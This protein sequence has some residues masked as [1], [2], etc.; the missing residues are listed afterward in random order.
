MKRVLIVDDEAVIREGMKYLI[1]WESLGY[2][3][4]GTAENGLVGLE[5]IRKLIPDLVMLDIKMPGKTGLQMLQEAREEGYNFHSIILSGYSDFEYA[6]KAIK[7]RT[8]SYLLKPVD[9]DELKE[10]LIDLS[11]KDEKVRNEKWTTILYDKLFGKDSTG[12][13]EYKQAKLIC[14]SSLLQLSSQF[15]KIFK[16]DIFYFT[17]HRFYYLLLTNN[18]ISDIEIERILQQKF[19]E[20][21]LIVT[22]WEEPS[23]GLKRLT[24]SV[25][26][27]SQFV[28]LYPNSLISHSQL[29]NSKE[30][31]GCYQKDILPSIVENLFDNE[32]LNEL[33]KQYQMNYYHQLNSEE[34]VKWQVLQDLNWLANQLKNKFALKMIWNSK[35]V[36]QT[37]FETKTIEQLLIVMKKELRQLQEEVSKQLNIQ[38]ITS[39][40]I[41]YTKKHYREDLSLKS[42]GE[43]FNYNSAYLGKKFRKDTGKTYLTYLEEIRMEKAKDIL[44]NS[45]LMVYEIAEMVGYSN[46]DYFY[47][48]F[49]N[50]FHISPNEFRKT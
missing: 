31:I 44:L 36:Q 2:Q 39:E 7:L 41:Q 49:K 43:H 30:T 8:A 21:E 48:K 26:Q 12:I 16:I 14:S 38:D 6:K 19:P 24:Q 9:E 47:K 35:N 5:M 32:K 25:D 13:V 18:N 50:H 27:L 20:K 4:V 23:N 42:I 17:S 3:V 37:I 1:D 40:I 29:E 28:F 33:L 11:I 22:D 15:P 34:S 10:I 46:V 45:N